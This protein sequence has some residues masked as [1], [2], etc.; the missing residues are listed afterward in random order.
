MKAKNTHLSV[1]IAVLG[2]L[3]MAFHPIARAQSTNQNAEI[4]TD[5]PQV[6]N[7][8]LAKETAKPGGWVN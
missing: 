1:A 7:A 6:S 4:S 5:I 2:L 3:S 8:E